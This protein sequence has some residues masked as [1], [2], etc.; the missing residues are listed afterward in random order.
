[1]RGGY[2]LTP[3]VYGYVEPGLD[4]RRYLI[5]ANDTN[6]YRVVAVNTVGLKSKPSAEAVAAPKP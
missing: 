6:G 2:W 4:L 5:G 1:M 3:Q